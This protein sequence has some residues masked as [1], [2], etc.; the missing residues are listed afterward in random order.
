MNSEH[1]DEALVIVD[2][3]NDFCPGGA[4]AVAGGD[5]VVEPINELARE[6]PLV[7]A[8]RDWHPP[9]H[10]SFIDNGGEWPVHCVRDSSGAQLHPRLRRERIGAIVDKG[11]APYGES[12]SGFAGTE[13]D[14]ILRR[15]GTRRVHVVGLALDYCVRQTALDARRLGFEVV[16]HRDLTR[17][18][19]VE[20]GDVERTL[21][22]LEAAGVELAP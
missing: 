10:D 9:D 20:A 2:V 21:A 18:I 6:F 5:E 17:A 19:D 1:T 8:T 13:L 4:L 15:A 7:I 16:L 22:E 12:Q 3:Q 11:V 14:A